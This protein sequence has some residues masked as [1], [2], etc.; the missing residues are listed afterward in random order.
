[1]VREPRPGDEYRYFDGLLT[2]D[3]RHYVWC[4]P[5]RPRDRARVEVIELLGGQLLHREPIMLPSVGDARLERTPDSRIVFLSSPAGRA[6]GSPPAGGVVPRDYPPPAWGYDTGTLVL[7]W[8]DALR[9]GRL[10]VHGEQGL[11]LTAAT[12][13][14]E[15]RAG[16]ALTLPDG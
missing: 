11:G 14:P 1:V 5:R 9:T 16:P 10:P 6:F 12:F 2:P 8:P 7:G 13:V 15:D 4:G 3:G